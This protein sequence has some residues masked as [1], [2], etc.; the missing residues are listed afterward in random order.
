MNFSS[1]FDAS[2]WILPVILAV[3]L[4]EASHGFVAWVFGDD[5][6][7]N[8]GRVTFN[9]LKHIDPMGTV[10]L[11]GLL[12]LAHAP[13]LFGYAKPVPVDFRK[14]E[15]KRLGMLL[16]AAAGPG[17]NILL[18]IISSLFLHL[19]AGEI[20]PDNLSWLQ[21][22]LFHS[23]LINSALAIFNM[24]PILPLDGGRV[25]RALLPGQIGNKYAKTERFGMLLVILLLMLP[26]LL[27]LNFV[28]DILSAINEALIG[29]VLFITGN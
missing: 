16:V 13:V 25:L 29:W 18:A 20:N 5:T 24:L 27:H 2:A 15:P 7:K 3:T 14:L 19:S 28:M 10:I 11:P 21:L 9:P 4:H 26:P 6:A 1:I 17:M 22:N 12:L 23:L 8:K